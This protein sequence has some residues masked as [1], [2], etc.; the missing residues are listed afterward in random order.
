MHKLIGPIRISHLYRTFSF[1]FLVGRVTFYRCQN[2]S[3]SKSIT[4][5]TVVLTAATQ[6]QLIVIIINLSI[7]ILNHSYPLSCLN[8][9][10]LLNTQKFQSFF[11]FGCHFVVLYN[12]R[13]LLLNAK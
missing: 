5:K 10:T 1:L 8:L 4:S 7:Y 12:A 6:E 13:E 11:R 2:L 9:Q 3:R